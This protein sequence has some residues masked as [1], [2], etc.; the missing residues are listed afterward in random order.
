MRIIGFTVP[1]N[2]EQFY[3]SLHQETY[4]NGRIAYLIMQNGEFVCDLSV[5]LPDEPLNDNEFFVKTWDDVNKIINQEVLKI[6]LFVKTERTVQAGYA[7]AE[8]WRL[9]T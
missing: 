4:E 9:N 6:G 5:N 7:T 8:V 2:E 3:L 1:I